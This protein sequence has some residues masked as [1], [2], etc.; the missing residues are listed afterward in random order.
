MVA[1]TAGSPE[2]L[3]RCRELGADLAISYRDDDFTAAVLEFTGG[4]GADVI[5]DIMGASYLA[6]NLDALAT[7]GRLV[8]IA[9]RGGSRAEVDLGC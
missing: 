2:K 6:G 4:H 8:V 7:W 3:A 1:C 9:T 5:L